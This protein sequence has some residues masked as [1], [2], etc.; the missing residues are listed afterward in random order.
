MA[1][2][3]S[4]SLHLLCVGRGT[5]P[6]FKFSFTLFETTPRRILLFAFFSLFLCVSFSLFSSHNS[7]YAN[8]LSV[9]YSS[10]PPIHPTRL[11]SS[12][13]QD[14][15]FIHTQSVLLPDWQ[16]LVIVSPETD[17]QLLSC[18]NF[19]CVY[20]NN[21]TAPA[22]FSG[23][24]P[25]TNQTTFK[26]LL[27]RSTRRRLPFAAPI[28]SDKESPVPWLWTYLVYESFSTE[29]DV[30]LFVK[31]LNN[32]QGLNRSPREFNGTVKTTVTSSIQEVFRCGHPDLTAFGSIDEHDHDHN[33]IK[34]KLSVEE[35]TA[36]GA[37]K[38]VPSVAYYTPRR[39]RAK[40]Q[41][42]SLLCASTMVYNVGKFLRE[43]IMYHSKIGVEK[44]ILY[45]NDSDDDLISIVKNLNEEGYNV[46]TLLWLWPKTQE[47][48]FSH[49]ALYA[50][51]SCKWMIYI[52]IDEFIFAPSWDNSSQP[53]DQMLKSLLPPS[54]T[55]RRHMIG[56]V[57]IIS[58][59]AEGVIQGYTC[60]RRLE[61]RHKSI[62]LLEAIDDSL[63]N[64]IHHFSLN[65]FAVV[66]HYK[67]QAWAEF[68][69]K[70]RRRVSAYVDRT[71]GLGYEA[72][73]PRGLKM[74]TRR[75][76][77]KQMGSR[78]TYRMAWQS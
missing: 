20:P 76:F 67:Y 77:G 44:F 57:W 23:I 48:G 16:V 69:A 51:D 32:R 13:F 38:V 46:E 70:F 28:L 6:T 62:V 53:S 12:S 61:N 40:S 52:D 45:D 27:P 68:K 29:D 47:A 31:G 74:L 14:F 10:L 64:V 33:P 35:T 50:K 9:N 15:I 7:I 8:H 17:S 71:P 58:H 4:P 21:A 36:T 2:G 1:Y 73:E 11:A 43:W 56:E 54:S 55:S 25:S 39:K 5:L 78:G 41:P 34:L 59:P 3:K 49:A 66:N 22:T 72:V 42:K 19:I 37:K 30:V 26:C 63:L 65:K 75:W 60:R 18:G 24:L